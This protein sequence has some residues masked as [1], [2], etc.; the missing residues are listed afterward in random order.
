MPTSTAII[1]VGGSA[2]ISGMLASVFCG[3]VTFLIGAVSHGLFDVASVLAVHLVGSAYLGFIIYGAVLGWAVSWGSENGYYHV[4]MLP[5]IAMYMD[6]GHFSVLGTLDMLCLCAPCAGVCSAVFVLGHIRNHTAFR[7]DSLSDGTQQ[8]TAPHSSECNPV[9]I[10]VEKSYISIPVPVQSCSTTGQDK[11]SSSRSPAPSRSLSVS[12]QFISEGLS[13]ISGNT[14]ETLDLIPDIPIESFVEVPQPSFVPS[15]SVQST[16]SP[17]VLDAV[18]T[19]SSSSSH[20]KAVP[21]PE[22]QSGGRTQEDYSHH[23]R[24]GLKGTVSNLLMGDYVEACYPYTLTN[25]WVLLSV[26]ISC[27]VS[28]AL[29]L[30]YFGMLHDRST[31]LSSCSSEYCDVSAPASNMLRKEGSHAFQ[32]SAYLPLP[33][34]MML[35]LLGSSDDYYDSACHNDINNDWFRYGT[36]GE[37]FLRLVH[38]NACT[39]LV[40]AVTVAYGLPFFTTM[41]IYSRKGM[42][43]PKLKCT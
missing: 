20:V 35:A 5:L 15:S 43:Q 36:I 8:S 40:L 33:L 29:V 30:G 25:R 38:P 24:L 32:S 17:S 22:S 18:P 4:V 14:F 26:R 10:N 7:S 31:S 21:A 19:S 27:A 11:H 41:V 37:A 2:I 1:S 28:G 42:L 16:S 13:A 23:I 6:Q 34:A 39:A 3:V 9:E 12:D